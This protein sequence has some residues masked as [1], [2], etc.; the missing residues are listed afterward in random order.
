MTEPGRSPLV[1][2][3]RDTADQEI[4]ECERQ[5][6]SAQLAADIAALDRLIADELLFTGPDGQLA[7]KAQDLDAHR[8]GLVRFRE[9]EPEELRIRH[10]G[11]NVAIVALRARLAVEVAGTL[12]RGTYRYTRIW[13]REDGAPWRVVGGHVSGVQSDG[14]G[15]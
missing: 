13:A 2:A 10:V 3:S 8:S 15:A 5:L 6:R 11:A 4:A 7:T 12:V 9:H 1:S 14:K